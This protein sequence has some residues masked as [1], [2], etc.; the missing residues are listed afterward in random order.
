MVHSDPLRSITL[1]DSWLENVANIF[2]YSLFSRSRVVVDVANSKYPLPTEVGVFIQHN[3]VLALPS[4]SSSCLRVVSHVK[5]LLGLKHLG[6]T[7][8]HAI[9]YDWAS[10]LWQNS[11]VF[12]CWT[13][14][15]LVK[16]LDPCLSVI[17][18]RLSIL[19]GGTLWRLLQRR[20][21]L[22]FMLINS[23]LDI[24]SYTLWV[25]VAFGLCLG[26][27]KKCF[28]SVGVFADLIQLVLARWHASENVSIVLPPWI[29]GRVVAKTLL[30]VGLFKILVLISRSFF[31]SCAHIRTVRILCIYE[32]SF[33]IDWISCT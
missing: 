27:W 33:W 5:E 2:R 7:L 12:H 3:L 31:L 16:F 32:W 11:A 14:L 10:L 23:L 22:L 1:W 25:V 6:F 4:L 28:P 13:H 9:R 15:A 21:F 8:F 24:S 17:H 19:V 29:V 26:K 30:W 20:F 18:E